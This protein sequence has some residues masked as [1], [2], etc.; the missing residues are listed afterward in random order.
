MKRRQ[1]PIIKIQQ[2]KRSVSA[3][4]LAFHPNPHGGKNGAYVIVPNDAVI[5]VTAAPRIHPDESGQYLYVNEMA[6]PISTRIS[7]HKQSRL[8]ND[9]PLI[10]DER[11]RSVR[12]VW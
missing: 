3:Q 4:L 2:T 9:K 5:E 8:M 7:L 12:F 1:L 11:A 6:L 10:Y